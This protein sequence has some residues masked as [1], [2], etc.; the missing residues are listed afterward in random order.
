MFG[1]ELAIGIAMA[2]LQEKKE[3]LRRLE[4]ALAELPPEQ[5]EAMR[6]KYIADEE[7]A[8]Q[9]ETAERRHQELCAAIRSTS[10]WRL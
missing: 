9:E 10:F 2:K 6:A 5:Q 8:R 3:R 4:A 1:L 7:K